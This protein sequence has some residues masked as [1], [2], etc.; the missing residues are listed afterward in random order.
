[1]FITLLGRFYNSK[2][3]TAFSCDLGNQRQWHVLKNTIKASEF[4]KRRNFVARRN[5]YNRTCSFFILLAN[6]NELSPSIIKSRK[7]CLSWK[8]DTSPT[9]HR[10]KWFITILTRACN[11]FLLWAR[12][13]QYQLSHTTNIDQKICLRSLNPFV[14]VLFWLET[15]QSRFRCTVILLI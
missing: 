8:N 7:E 10:R 3:H 12:W 13:I 2:R 1:M 6:F 14:R 15:E 5:N 4:T 11:W 9:N